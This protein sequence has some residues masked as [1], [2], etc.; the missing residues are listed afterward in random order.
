LT[1]SVPT[2]TISET[3]WTTSVSTYTES[4]TSTISVFTSTWTSTTM[5]TFTTSANTTKTY[6]D[7]MWHTT[8]PPWNG[9]FAHRYARRAS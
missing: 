4:P 1:T 7:G 9:T 8:Y 5:M 3:T 2:Y 6:D